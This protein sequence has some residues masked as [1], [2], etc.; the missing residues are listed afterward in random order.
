MVHHIGR[1]IIAPTYSRWPFDFN[2]FTNLA[3][4]NK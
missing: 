4:Y 1:K 3:F 2:P